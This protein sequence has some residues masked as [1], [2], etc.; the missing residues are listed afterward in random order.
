MANLSPARRYTRPAINDSLEAIA[1]RDLSAQP[2]EE[3]VA[4]LRAW[5]PHLALRR[6]GYLL[7][8][9]VVFLEP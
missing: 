2:A 4:N 5:N 7:V 9:D 8:S 1:A 6:G 3:A